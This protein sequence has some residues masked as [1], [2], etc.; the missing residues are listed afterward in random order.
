VLWLLA[1][2][3][4]FDLGVAEARGESATG[5]GRDSQRELSPALK[6]AT[7][8]TRSTG[9]KNRQVGWR[10]I[11]EPDQGYDRGPEFCPRRAGE[12]SRVGMSEKDGGPGGTRTPNQA[13]M[14]RRL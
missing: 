14:S 7:N 6:K 13:V 3:A 10:S 5:Q 1:Q 2:R 12:R 4:L 8:E 11:H 9:A